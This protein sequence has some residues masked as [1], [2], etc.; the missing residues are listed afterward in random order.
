MDLCPN[1]K[2]RKKKTQK[3]FIYK[4][5]AIFCHQKS[6]EGKNEDLVEHCCIDT[7]QTVF[8]NIRL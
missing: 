5:L 3:K 6:K 7:T 4:Q 1:K 2:E 8:L